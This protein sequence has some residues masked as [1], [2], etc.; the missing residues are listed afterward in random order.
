MTQVT[1][2]IMTELKIFLASSNELEQERIKLGNEIASLNNKITKEGKRVELIKWEDLNR[3]MHKDGVQTRF[4]EELLKSDVAVILIHK[5]VGKFTMEEFNQAYSAMIQGKKPKWIYVYFK[6]LAPTPDEIAQKEFRRQIDAVYDLKERI[7]QVEQNMVIP[8][9]SFEGLWANL[10][11]QLEDVFENEGN[12]N[13]ANPPPPTKTIAKSTEWDSYKNSALQL[14]RHLIMASYKT[15]IRTAI[16]LEKIYVGMKAKIHGTD[17]E[18]TKSGMQQLMDWFEKEKTQPM[19]LRAAIKAA[20][21]R[22]IKSLA[23]LGNPGCGKT[24][25][26]KYILVILTE[27]A[28]SDTLGLDASLIPFFAPLRELKDPNKESFLDFIHRVCKL[29]VHALDQD[30][31]KKLLQRKKGII[32]LDGLDEV[33]DEEVR[34][35]TC[36]WIDKARQSY[37]DTLFL[38]T[39]R[40]GSYHGETRLSNESGAVLELSIQ[41]F[42]KEEMVIFLERWFEA[43]ETGIHAGEDEEHWRSEGRKKARELA[44]E[45]CSNENIFQLAVNPL[46]LQILALL[47]REKDIGL[48]E[49]RVELYQRWTNVLLAYWEESKETD[50]IPAKQVLQTFALLLHEEEGRRSAPLAEVADWIKDPLEKNGMSG[51]DPE[52][53]LKKIRD[54]SGIVF[55]YNETEYG[56]THLRFQEYFAAEEI[57]DKELVK[58][59]IQNYKSE[60]WYE[61]ILLSLALNK[62]SIIEPFMKQIISMDVFEK[63]ISHVLDAVKDSEVKPV[64]VFTEALNQG[65]LSSL[66]RQNVLRVLEQMPCKKSELA[67]KMA[68]ASRDK[69]LAVLAY[70]ILKNSGMAEGLEDPVPTR[71]IEHEKDHSMLVLVPAGSFYYGSRED[72]N[73]AKRDEKPQNTIELPDFYIDKY[74]V[75]NK[76]YKLFVDETKHRPPNQSNKDAEELY[77]GPIWE[78]NSYPQEYADHPV[79]CVSLEDARAYAKWAG[80]RLPTEQEWEKAA[81]G[82]DGRNYPWG[83][84]FDD[85]FCNHGRKFKGTTAVGSFEKGV[86]PYGCHDMAGNVWEWTDSTLGSKPVVR[87]GSWSADS[88][89]CRCAYRGKYEYRSVNNGFR[90][91]LT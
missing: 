41:D 87:G 7:E 43:V 52:A 55:G 24:I 76:Q 68:A 11:A 22:R 8:Y 88:M 65:S 29:E 79:M 39:S 40:F 66:A 33:A 75:T 51:V 32:L 90:C 38:V 34:L 50:F 17:Y 5:R 56:F 62:P 28:Q 74:Q 63:D 80:K 42:T 89:Y 64:E 49:R 4:T 91:A 77:G 57:R 70:N 9:E 13:G 31:L 2:K 81:R 61:V 23:I 21:N 15:T 48:P 10:K 85:K 18:Y 44:K 16:E 58:L 47:R 12:T 73:E 67:L 60:W 45:I 84:E 26:L 71:V 53:V 14:H 54:R 3:A 78:G 82:W 59:L 1:K 36:Q 86:S 19:D 35:Q 37:A 27:G 83:N 72:D 20:E 30:D 46:I 25:L 69:K 6:N